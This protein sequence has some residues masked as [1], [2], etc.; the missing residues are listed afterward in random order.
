MLLR[1]KEPPERPLAPTDLS[2]RNLTCIY[3]RPSIC[4]PRFPTRGDL[5]LFFPH[6]VLLIVCPLVASILVPHPQNG[7]AL[8]SPKT[9]PAACSADVKPSRWPTSPCPHST[10]RYRVG[11]LPP[12]LDRL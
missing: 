11:T 8:R 5:P 9:R 1:S 3:H 12:A 2:H 4:H 6:F 7:C 10:D